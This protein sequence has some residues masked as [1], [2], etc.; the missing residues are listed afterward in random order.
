MRLSCQNGKSQDWL[1]IEVFQRF[2]NIYLCTAMLVGDIVSPHCVQ[3]ILNGNVDEFD[4]QM[5]YVW[6]IKR[7]KTTMSSIIKP[8]LVS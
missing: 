3:P 2:S 6:A 5:I 4:K 8:T 1:F 7:G